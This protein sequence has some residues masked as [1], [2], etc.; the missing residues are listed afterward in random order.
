MYDFNTVPER[1]SSLSVRL[2]T[3]EVVS[4]SEQAAASKL[5]AGTDCGHWH[6]LCGNLQECWQGQAQGHSGPQ[7]VRYRSTGART[8]IQTPG[9][10]LTAGKLVLIVCRVIGIQ[11]VCTGTGNFAQQPSLDPV[12]CTRTLA[13]FE[14]RN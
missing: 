6:V 8:V 2:T 3:G 14:A 5:R 1:C 13:A 9:G 7:H 10:A 11:N 4:R 12:T